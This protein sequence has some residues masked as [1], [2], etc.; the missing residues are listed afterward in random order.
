M[1]PKHIPHSRK[2]GLSD[3]RDIALK[4]KID[5]ALG[6]A[7]GDDRTIKVISDRVFQFEIDRAICLETKCPERLESL[8]REMTDFIEKY[9]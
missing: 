1:N 7:S 4:E 3:P 9:L 8:H 2:S 6:K 5:K